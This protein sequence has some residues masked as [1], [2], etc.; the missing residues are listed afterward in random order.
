MIGNSQ[1][2][3]LTRKKA[4]ISRANDILVLL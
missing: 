2:F 1:N 3:F 4:Q